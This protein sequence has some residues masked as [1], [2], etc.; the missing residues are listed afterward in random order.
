MSEKDVSPES[1]L[2][3][4]EEVLQRVE[5][6]GS[7]VKRL[8]VVTLFVSGL[9]SLSY[10]VEIVYPYL[11]GPATETVN[12]KDPTLVVLEAF[13]TAMALLWFYVGLSDFRFVARLSS[14]VA[15]A[16]IRERE[17]E[18]EIT[19]NRAGS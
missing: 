3:L 6:F 8:S 2:E 12:L 10:V 1:V 18:K 7:R 16:R 4:R 13:L 14:L 19:S 5:K 17:I 9:L 15:K 11:G